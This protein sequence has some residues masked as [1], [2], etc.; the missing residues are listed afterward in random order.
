MACIDSLQ[1]YIIQLIYFCNLLLQDVHLS[2][3][4]PVSDLGPV[5][6]TDVNEGCNESFNGS[7][8][9]PAGLACYTGIAPGSLVE[10]T[11][12]CPQYGLEGSGTRVCQD[13]GTW[14]GAVPQ[15]LPHC[16]L[17]AFV[18]KVADIRGSA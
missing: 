16:T 14:T 7:V 8:Q 10:Y 9:I 4:C 17:T 2:V 5:V 12:N 15:C 3:D 1:N 13:D 18:Y 6:D 11:C